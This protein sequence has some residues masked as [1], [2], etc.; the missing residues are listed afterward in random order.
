M[1]LDLN[2]GLGVTGD[3]TVP[4]FD[5]WGNK[6]ALCLKFATKGVNCGF[7]SRCT[8]YHLS[9]KAFC[10]MGNAA[11]QEIDDMVNSLPNIKMAKDILKI[12][13]LRRNVSLTAAPTIS[14]VTGENPN[15]KTTFPALGHHWPAARQKVRD[16]WA[17]Y[18]PP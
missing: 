5:F 6:R 15:L 7:R 8:K 1:C 14:A 13:A 18:A 3:T 9:E 12:A 16:N 11:M 17:S 2:K 4:S 10:N